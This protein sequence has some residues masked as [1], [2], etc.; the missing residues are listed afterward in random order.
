MKR[1]RLFMV[2]LLPAAFVLWTTPLLAQES[3]APDGQ[4]GIQAGTH[5]LGAQY[6]LSPGL[7]LGSTI[8]VLFGD[9]QTDI[10]LGPYV[11]FLLEGE[12]NPMFKVGADLT[13]PEVG[14]SQVDIW[15]AFGLE[16]FVTSNVGV[17]GCVDIF[18][19]RASPDPTSITVGLFSSG[20][21][22]IEMFID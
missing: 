4:F 15:A 13:L 6:A 19:Y 20:H 11:K 5:G 10:N 8:G 16:Y 21:V 22:G 17:F 3:V 14:D 12:I 18:R 7:H 2:G 1:F 9:V